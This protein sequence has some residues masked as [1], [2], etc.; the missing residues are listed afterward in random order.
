MKNNIREGWRMGVIVRFSDTGKGE[1]WFFGKC[2]AGMSTGLAQEMQNGW[3][4]A[5]GGRLDYCYLKGCF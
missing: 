1:I 3:R 2:A 5:A 4:Q